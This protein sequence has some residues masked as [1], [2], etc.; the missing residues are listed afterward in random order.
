M[1]WDCDFERV[2]AEYPRRARTRT[3]RCNSPGQ[4]PRRGRTWWRHWR[5]GKQTAWLIVKR[6]SRQT[7]IPATPHAFR[8]A[9]ATA[10]FN[11]GA[12]LSLIEICVATQTRL[13][14]TPSMRSTS[15]RRCGQGV[16]AV[17]SVDGCAGCFSPLTGI[18]RLCSAPGGFLV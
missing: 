18:E 16:R 15:S 9:M 17:Q 10:T 8:D 3:H 6:Y 12:G 5:M 1:F 7:G 11:K 13:S 14:R 2:I 4:P